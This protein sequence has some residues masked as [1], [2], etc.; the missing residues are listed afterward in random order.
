MEVKILIAIFATATAQEGAFLGK[1]EVTAS[2]WAPDEGIKTSE[3]FS[4]CKNGDDAKRTVTWEDMD[5]VMADYSSPSLSFSFSESET[6]GITN[7]QETWTWNGSKWS[8]ST[9]WS[10]SDTQRDSST[11]TNS[12]TSSEL[13]TCS[14]F[15]KTGTYL[16]KWV[17][18]TGS[19]KKIE[20]D[21]TI[22]TSG[23]LGYSIR[24]EDGSVESAA[25][26]ECS[27]RL[28]FSYTEPEEG[29]TTTNNEM[30]TVSSNSKIIGTTTWTWIDGT[31]D[32]DSGTYSFS[33]SSSSGDS[34]S[35]SVNVGM[36]IGVIIACVIVCTCLLWIAVRCRYR[37][38]EQFN[39]SNFGDDRD[40][41]CG[42]K[43]QPQTQTAIAV[44]VVA[45]PVVPVVTATAVVAQPQVAYA[46]AVPAY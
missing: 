29:G 25:W 42:I 36:I 3:C 32:T 17:P 1:W 14:G 24:F 35:S 11:G 23:S 37:S 44:A 21:F 27:S 31:G 15:L 43:T 40:Q 19:G 18:L 33:A 13:R 26:D 12:F 41:S 34:S 6:G 28:T 10:W 46:Q 20:E 2:S 45:Q 7:N 38:A 8:G 16:G 22:E 39:D 9:S 4:I 30:W 5:T